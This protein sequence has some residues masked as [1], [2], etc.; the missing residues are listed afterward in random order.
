M[1]R[2]CPADQ[3]RRDSRARRSCRPTGIRRDLV[4]CWAALCRPYRGPDGEEAAMDTDVT[5][6]VA[7]QSVRIVGPIEIDGLPWWR[8]PGCAGVRATELWRSGDA[9]DA[10]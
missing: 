4:P 5:E 1:P 7:G 9:H 6:R 10:L 8:V 3:P 2:P